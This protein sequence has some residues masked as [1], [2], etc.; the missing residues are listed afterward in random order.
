MEVVRLISDADIPFP[1]QFSDYLASM[2]EGR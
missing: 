2:S 1:L